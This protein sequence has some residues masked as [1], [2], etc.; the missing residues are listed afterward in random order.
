[1]IG[2]ILGS[3]EIVTSIGARGMGEVCRARDARL[4]RDV[5]VKVLPDTVANGPGWKRFHSHPCFVAL[6]KKMGLEE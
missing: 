1:M 2:I 4:G 6:L 5:A 3:Y